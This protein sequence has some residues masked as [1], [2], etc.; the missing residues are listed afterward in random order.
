MSPASGRRH[1]ALDAGQ[2][3]D[4]DQIR[5]LKLLDDVTFQLPTPAMRSDT[6]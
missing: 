6:P 3:H 4:G 5:Q 2:Q 1:V